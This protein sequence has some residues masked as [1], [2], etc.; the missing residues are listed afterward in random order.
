MELKIA[1]NG[2]GFD[3]RYRERIFEPFQRLNSTDD[4]EGSGIG[5]AICRK[6]IE[7]HGGAVTAASSRGEG[8]V[9]TITLPLRPLP[10]SVAS[11]SS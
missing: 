10:A 2:I 8:S 11:S 3:R 1:D 7:R 9:F 6:I 4:Y 5:L